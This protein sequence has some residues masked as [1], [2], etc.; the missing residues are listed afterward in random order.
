MSVTVIVG[1]AKMTFRGK[2]QRCRA[3][4]ASVTALMRGVAQAGSL[5]RRRPS[6]DDFGKANEERKIG[7]SVLIDPVIEHTETRVSWESPDCR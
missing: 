5:V 2:L 1:Q 6:V 3:G 7:A 4:Q